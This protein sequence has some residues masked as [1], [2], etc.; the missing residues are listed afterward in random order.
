MYFKSIKNEANYF[1]KQTKR[2]FYTNLANENS[3][4]QK[5]L[6]VVAKNLLTPK[7]DLRFP[8]HHDMNS[9]ANELDQYF[10]TKVETIP[11]QLNSVGTQHASIPSST[12]TYEYG[13]LRVYCHIIPCG[14]ILHCFIC[15]NLWLEHNHIHSTNHN[16]VFERSIFHRPHLI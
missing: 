9:L 16:V 1:M 12:I 6:H 15:M 11:S 2:D 8:N 4:N 10:T 3:H 14:P 7:K 5:K 13:F